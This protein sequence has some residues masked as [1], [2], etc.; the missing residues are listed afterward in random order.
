[1]GIGPTWIQTFTEGSQ[2]SLRAHFQDHMMQG[3]D[4]HPISDIKQVGQRV[5]KFGTSPGG[6]SPPVLPAPR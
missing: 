6:T 3:M 4:N 5:I 1:M 2:M